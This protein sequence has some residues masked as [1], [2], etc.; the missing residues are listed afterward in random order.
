MRCNLDRAWLNAAQRLQFKEPKPFLIKLRQIERSGIL[1]DA[2]PK[3]RDL[4]TN[5]L[6]EW[7][8]A[9]EAAL[10]CYGM[11]ERIGQ[12][13]YFAKSE[14]QD[15]DFVATWIVGSN[16]HLAPVQLKE[17]VPTKLNPKA[18][19]ESTIRTLSK[20]T[21]SEGL[22][23]AIHLNQDT[24]IERENLRIPPLK[25]AA[26]WIFATL[27]PDQSTWGLW[28]NFL[29]PDPGMSQFNYPE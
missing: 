17:V 22:T 14:S 19:L 1:A 4:R 24:R 8:E 5:K 28:G 2:P 9:R 12:P 20:Y 13:V 26:L 23:V 6:K 11:G 10:F 3:V 18:S 29:E 16:Q 7:R 15:Y 21:D 25:L 27:K